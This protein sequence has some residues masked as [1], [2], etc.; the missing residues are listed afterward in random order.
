MAPNCALA[1]DK[2]E[3]EMSRIQGVEKREKSFGEDP[4]YVILSNKNPTL[5]IGPKGFSSKEASLVRVLLS[6]SFSL[7]LFHF[8]YN[9]PLN[10]T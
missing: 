6:L 3:K 1:E 9:H 5:A 10:N 7:S 8:P 4:I 2:G